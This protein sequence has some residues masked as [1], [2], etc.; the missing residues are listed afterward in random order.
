MPKLVC[1]KCNC[2]FKIEKNGMSAIEMVRGEPYEMSSADKWKCPGCGMEILAG[3]GLAPW[4]NQ[5][6]FYQA[7]IQEYIKA[8]EGKGTLVRY[9]DRL[10]ASEREA[11]EQLTK[12]YGID[13][14]GDDE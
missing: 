12:E 3:F 11:A 6:Q 14:V 2:L 7:N 9:K 5:H 10:S 8:A 4:I 1:L 13:F